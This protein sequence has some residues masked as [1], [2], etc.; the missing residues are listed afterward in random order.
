MKL[1]EHYDRI[2]EILLEKKKGR[3]WKGYKPTPGVKPYA[4]GSCQP[5]SEGLTTGASPTQTGVRVGK[6]MNKLASNPDV[7]P[8]HYAKKQDQ[9]ARIAHRTAERQ[10]QLYRKERAHNIRQGN[11]IINTPSQVYYDN[12]RARFANA[13]RANKP[14][15]GQQDNNV[16][17]SKS[18]AWQRSEGKSESGGLNAKG[19]ASYRRANPGSKLSMAVTEKKP[20]GKRAKRRASFC[21]RMRGMKKKLTSK[22]TANDPDSRINKAL[23]KWNC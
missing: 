19:I 21:R 23:R 14:T 5:V 12:S 3:C 17:E 7:T 16:Q 18:P 9:V 8:E 22:K 1:N 11:A 2:I 6:F 4:K 10:R 15:S 13:Y 20:K